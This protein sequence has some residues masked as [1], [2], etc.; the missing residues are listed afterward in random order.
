MN[1]NPVSI[2]L[3]ERQLFLDDH[4]VKETVNLDR[5]MHSPVKRGTVIRP[6]AGEH[7]LQTRCVPFWD[8]NDKV[9]KYWVGGYRESH[10][11]LN[12]HKVPHEQNM[13]VAR[14]VF[15]DPV[16]PDPTRRFKAW[17]P[18]AF[19]VSGD[20]STWH[21]L[22]VKPIPAGDDYNFSLDQQNRLYIA[23]VKHS[24]TYGRSIWLSTSND[25][26]EWTEPEF[27]F[28]A[29]ELDQELA[30]QRIAEW[31]EDPIR[32]HPYINVP[33]HYGVDIYN[34]GAFRYEGLYIGLPSFF[35]HTG[36]V[37]PDWPG[38]AEMELAPA[39]QE[40]IAEYG[41]YS[42]FHHVQLAC[43]RDLRNWQRL[44]NRQPFIDCSPIDS[45]AHDLSSVR[46]AS[47]VLICGDELWFY[48]TGG[49]YYEIIRLG[50]ADCYAI[51]LAV[52]RRDGFVSLD[53]GEET[54][55]VMTRAIE[56]PS[57]ARHLFVNADLAN[58][59]L[60]AVVLEANGRPLDGFT[61]PQVLLVP[62]KTTETY[63]LPH[64]SNIITGDQ[65]KA[66]LV[67]DGHEDLSVLAGREISL[68]LALSNGSL[69]SLWFE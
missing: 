58:G 6:D 40:Y 17:Q 1:D 49:K 29:D 20:G 7:A 32:P 15:Y 66:E 23:T 59:E 30:R 28:E 54:G 18:D 38:Y 50:E 69:Y 65:T 67:W 41:D 14:C 25:F 55:S 62:G 2:P 60:R 52:L 53:A 34:M 12:W 39:A 61:E 44:G 33:Q 16:D 21:E 9:F 57:G 11:G 3:N 4:V 26:E 64:Y 43:S 24:A 42:G 46:P 31:F 63:Y 10:D 22:E 45:G 48:Y 35:H 51:C 19:H 56:V 68:R 5:V 13:E 8:S 27:I 37:R 36:T 47:N